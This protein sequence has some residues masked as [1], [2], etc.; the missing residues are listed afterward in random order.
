MI[1]GPFRFDATNECV[2]RGAEAI[3]LTPKAFAVLRHLVTHP[4][5]LVTKEELLETVWSETYVSDAVLKVCVGEIRK[6]LGDDAKT[7]QFIETVHRRGYR[8]LPAITTQPVPRSTFHVSSSEPQHSALS[9]QHSVLVGRESEL[10][11]LHARLEN[12]LAG[13]RQIVFVTG[14]SG[15]GKSTLIDAFLTRV[16]NTAVVW[17]ARGQCLAHYGAGE[18]YL[19]VLEALGRLGREASR[20]KLQAVLDRY[21]PTWLAQLP[22]LVNI[23]DRQRLQRETLNATPERML[24]EMAEALEALTTDTPLI[25]VLE[26]LHWSD[27]STL[28]LIS[29]LARRREPARLLL[30]GL[31]RPAE[32][33]LSSHPLKKVKQELLAHGLCGELALES[34]DVRAV[35]TYLAGRFMEGSAATELAPFVYRQTRGHPLFMV[36]AVEHLIGQGVVSLDGN[37]WSVTTSLDSM[38][39]S[40]PAGLQQ[41]IVQRLERLQA[42]EQHALEAASVVGGEFTAAAAAVALQAETATVEEVC[43][44]LVQRGQFLYA[45]GVREEPNGTVSACYRFAHFLYQQALSERVGAARRLRLQRRIGEWVEAVYAERVNEVAAELAMRF[46]SSH[47]YERAVRYLLLAGENAMR[48]HAPREAAVSF[49]KGLRLLYALPVTPQHARQELNLQMALGPALMAIHGYA[50]DEVE[51]AYRRACDLCQQ[52]DDSSRLFPALWGLWLFHLVRAEFATA[53]VLGERLLELAHQ[54]HDPALLLQAHNALGTTLYHC[55]EFLAARE[56]VERGVAVYRADRHHPLALLYGGE[57]PGVVC[58]CIFALTLWILGYPEQAEQQL[59]VAETLAHSLDHPFSLADALGFAAAFHQYGRQPAETLRR[60]E[61]LVNVAEAQGFP[62]WSAA[63]TML[64]GWGL[65]EQGQREDGV[66][67]LCLGLEAH[68]TAGTELFRPY[69]L[70]LLADAYRKMGRASEGLATLAE[71]FVLMDRSDERVY[72]AELYRLKGELLLMNGTGARASA[73]V[74]EPEGKRG[75][76]AKR[77][78]PRSTKARRV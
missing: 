32:V 11:Q 37:A 67:C 78:R 1:F 53:R 6:A 13:Q 60:A 64:R 21:A 24:R 5:R 54:A 33:G 49:A 71:A 26:D 74:A 19:P 7:P 41:I 45:V 34:L 66:R 25:L 65:V 73:G 12:A 56:Q 48:R 77:R 22:A 4:G 27:Y 57:D 2:W 61:A 52:L 30:V 36:N 20:E 62:Y 72:E 44:G 3:S 50:A 16:A 39:I 58:S 10:A 70:G 69:W 31:Y 8:F 63:G 28:D 35:T 76:N 43:D 55:G 40:A 17:I 75:S 47:D 38:E 14:E 59:R 46:E 9:T 68:R 29:A 23:E 51:R 15:V 18:A 42:E